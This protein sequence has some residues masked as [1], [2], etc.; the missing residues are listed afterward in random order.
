M[1]LDETVTQIVIDDILGNLFVSVPPG[2]IACIYSRGR[3][4]LPRILK[5]G[6]HLKIPFWHKAKLFNVQVQEYPIQQ[7]FLEEE[8]KRVG[9]KEIIA[10]T[11][12]DKQVSIEGTML[13]KL[14]EKN[15]TQLWQDIGDDFV[16][17][18]IRPI[19]RSRIRMVVSNYSSVD[20]LAYQSQLEQII[21]QE[22]VPALADKSL[23]VENFLLSNISLVRT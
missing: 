7:G 5:P 12:D 16:K 2:Y 20:V 14:N 13:F 9:D 21:R 22:L 23:V 19:T 18:I 4:V 10:L 1:G 15:V 11:A 17:K 8:E 6:L 3:G